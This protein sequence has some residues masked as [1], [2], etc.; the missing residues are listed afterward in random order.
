M[1]LFVFVL[2]GLMVVFVF[3][4]V[5]LVLFVLG[6]IVVMLVV[7]VEGIVLCVGCV[8]IDVWFFGELVV[9]IGEEVR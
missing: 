9:F 5:V 8:Y 4:V 7:L 1:V 6:F 2:I 3:G